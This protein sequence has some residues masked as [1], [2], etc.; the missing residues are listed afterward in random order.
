MR[1]MRNRV[2]SHDVHQWGTSFL[3]ALLPEGETGR[4]SPDGEPE[5]S[6]TE[7]VAR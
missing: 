1:K 3:K 6:E 5:E 4:A 7:V 2:R